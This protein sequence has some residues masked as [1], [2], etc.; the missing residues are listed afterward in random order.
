MSTVVGVQKLSVMMSAQLRMLGSLDLVD[1]QTARSTRLA[2]DGPKG[3]C[4]A[5]EAD[6][7]LKTETYRAAGAHALFLGS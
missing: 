1:M 5:V 2:Q 4:L 6:P 7:R 3:I